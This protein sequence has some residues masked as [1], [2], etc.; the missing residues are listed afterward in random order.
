MDALS[1]RTRQL[2][3]W[4]SVRQAAHAVRATG[5]EQSVKPERNERSEEVSMS[6]TV[7]IRPVNR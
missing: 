7:V 5:K 6:R 4:S 1:K 2:L 3:K